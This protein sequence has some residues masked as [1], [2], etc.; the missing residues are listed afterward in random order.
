[1][2]ANTDPGHWFW[3]GV[4][5]A[6]FYYV[7]CSPCID[8]KYKKQRR[9]EAK[10]ATQVVVTTEPGVIRQP[11]AFQTNEQ[12]AEELILGPG[13]PEPWKPDELLARV[14]QKF[15][16]SAPQATPRP[17]LDRR[18]ST[19]LENV[20]DSLRH[21]LHPD[22]WNWK[23]YDRED[24]NLGVLGDKMTR[25]WDRVTNTEQ[26]GRRRA[27]TNESDRDYMR[28]RIPALNDLHPAVVSQLP[29]TREDAAWMLLPPPSA[30]VMNGKKRPGDDMIQRRPLCVIGRPLPEEPKQNE[31]DWETDAETPDVE[32]ER[33]HHDR[34]LSEPIPKFRP[35]ADERHLSEPLPNIA[36]A[37]PTELFVPKPRNLFDAKSDIF[38]LAEAV[39]PKTRPSSWQFFI[40]PTQ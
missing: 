3:R 7:S 5:S 12:W 8:Y 16:P 37:V 22:K 4:Q 1:M 30:A 36:A 35:P 20:K 14:K 9:R 24:E 17:S 31:E 6:I 15:T 2:A 32:P 39:T 27:H 38:P 40:I 23:R 19:T 21:S 29:A 34:H 18:I 11:T 33:P 10:I 13:P 28:G 26:T 25:I